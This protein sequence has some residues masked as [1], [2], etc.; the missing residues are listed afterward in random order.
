MNCT[1]R[2]ILRFKVLGVILSQG[3]LECIKRLVLESKRK[4]G[5]HCF[6]QSISQAQK[7]SD[8]VFVLKSSLVWHGQKTLI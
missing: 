6:L 2:V 4:T 3:A 8:F 5:L 1:E 7:S